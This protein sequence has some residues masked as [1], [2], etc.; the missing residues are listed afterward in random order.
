M[1]HVLQIYAFAT[2]VPETMSK[3]LRIRFKTVDD[4]SFKKDLFWFEHINRSIVL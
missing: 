2:K 1:K 4:E 3:T